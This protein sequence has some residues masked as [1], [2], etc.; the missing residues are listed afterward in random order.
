MSNLELF[1]KNEGLNVS[2]RYTAI[3]SI[4][5]VEL[6]IQHGFTVSKIL[7]AGV[8]KQE[9]NG[10]QRH[11]IRMR[12]T[13]FKTLSV[14]DAL[15]EIVIENSY[16]GGS[17]LKL[18]LG[19]FVLLCSNG[20]VVGNTV[21][22]IKIKH[23]GDI[24][25]HV[26]ESA[27]DLVARASILSEVINQWKSIDLD[28]YSQLKLVENINNALDFKIAPTTFDRFLKVR[29]SAENKS[30]LWTVFNR[31]QENFVRG[32]IR[33]IDVNGEQ[34]LNREIK[35]LNRL[36]DVNKVIWNE[37]SNLIKAA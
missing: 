11:I 25:K 26:I 16:D 33:Y 13:D 4:E 9:N 30:D 18:S 32:G 17:C 7:K 20:L 24:K 10:F 21:Q 34:K 35:A 36:N 15:P 22:G 3:N 6:M 2:K 19:I 1:N 12:H 29:R 27:F 14:G 31:L 5:L 23:V 28:Y 37:A 8:R